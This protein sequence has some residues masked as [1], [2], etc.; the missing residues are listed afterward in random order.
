MLTKDEWAR[1]E[2]VY[3]GRVNLVVLDF[4]TSAA[5]ERS[6]IEAERL[7]L[8]QFFDEYVG[9]TGFDAIAGIGSAVVAE[10]RAG[11]PPDEQPILNGVMW[12][13]LGEADPTFYLAE[14][15]SG[16]WAIGTVAAAVALWQDSGWRVAV[17][18]ALGGL[19]MAYSHFPP[20]GAVAGVLLSLAAWLFLRDTRSPSHAA[21][22]LLTLP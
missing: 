10:Y 4:T 15:A 19:V 7:A 3:A 11:L 9:A 12:S 16:A 18:L 5:T 17:P 21:S 6:R 20:H 13:L 14:V 1:I 8:G 22:T 2:Q